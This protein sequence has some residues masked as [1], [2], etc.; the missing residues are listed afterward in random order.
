[1]IW[2]ACGAG[3]SESEI[4]EDQTAEKGD[5]P[6][7]D[8]IKE[9]LDQLGILSPRKEAKA[10][11]FAFLDLEGRTVRLN[12]FKDRVIFLHFWATWCAPCRGE[13]PSIQKLYDTFKDREDFVLLAVSGD[14]KGLDV[15][16]PFVQ[17]MK[18]TIPVF[19]DSKGQGHGLYGVRS[20]PITYL[21]DRSGRVIGGA[22]GPRKWDGEVAQQLF[23]LLLGEEPEE[24]E[25][26]PPVD[27]EVIE[28]GTEEAIEE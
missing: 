5:I 2:A 11:D 16:E 7:E 22:M 14:P 28:E 27:E 25:A 8:A 13:L 24:A 10:V 23:D 17:R 4:P 26:N 12:D 9:Y 6:A 19:W 21:I 3:D 20:I 18:L 15:I 1:V